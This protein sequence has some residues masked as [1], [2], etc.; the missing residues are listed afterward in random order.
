MKTFAHIT[1]ALFLLLSV[2]VPTRSQEQSVPDRRLTNKEV[3]AMFKAGLSPQI[4]IAK[5]KRSATGFDT[6]TLALSE[7]KK[8]GVTEDVLLV[9]LESETQVVTPDA[10]GGKPKRITDELTESFKRHQS[11]V[12]TIW[13]EIGRGTGFI[14]DKGG[15][16]MTNQHVI[17]PSG[18][19][20]VQFDGQRKIPAVLLT[21]NPEKDVAVLW[22]NISAFPEASVAQIASASS[23][24]PPVIEGERVLTIGSPLHQ[25]KIMTTGIVSKVEKAAKTKEKRNDKD[26]AVEGTFRPLDEFKNWEFYVGEYTPVLIIRATPNFGES[27]WGALGR[28]MAAGYGIHVP[29]KM[30]FKTDFYRMRLM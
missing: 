21:A 16:I 3:V 25:R 5:I 12:V 17:G 2:S 8:N 29:A 26:G 13:S 22:A 23:D 9:M 11:T 24:E 15:L 14:F 4:I 19:V 27:F 20:A 7:L 10:P 1:L 18:Y 30:R 6:S 28:G